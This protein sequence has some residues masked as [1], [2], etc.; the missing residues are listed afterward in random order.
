MNQILIHHIPVEDYRKLYLISPNF[1]PIFAF[2]KEETTLM[3]QNK[4]SEVSPR[5]KKANLRKP[6]QTDLINSVR[7][8]AGI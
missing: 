3:L 1:T 5:F 6:K 7:V 2:M 8:S 4:E